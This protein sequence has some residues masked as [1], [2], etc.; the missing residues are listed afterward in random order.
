MV[1]GGTKGRFIGAMKSFGYVQTITIFD[2]P[3]LLKP[4]NWWKTTQPN[5]EPL[6]Q[7]ARYRLGEC[8]PI[9]C[10]GGNIRVELRGSNLQGVH[11]NQ[12]DLSL[13]DL[14]LAD[15]QRANLD[16]TRL[17]MAKL[18]DADFRGASLRGA[19]LRGTSFEPLLLVPGLRRKTYV[20]EGADL[21][22][23]NLEEATGLDC[24]MI[25]RARNWELAIRDKDLACGED[26]PPLCCHCLSPRISGHFESEDSGKRIR[27]TKP[28]HS[29]A[30]APRKSWSC[31][32][33]SAKRHQRY[34]GG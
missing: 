1:S 27:Y 24:D 2:E 13:S 15:L 9:E 23:A 19:Y 20:F 16:G 7:W 33:F 25:T 31:F 28:N 14:S 17:T 6:W 30:S 21:E 10:G 32:S 12:V 3:E 18:S 5:I 34:L 22:R 29:P 26:I 8:T 4:W 11:L